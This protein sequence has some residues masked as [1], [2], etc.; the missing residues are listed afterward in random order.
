MPF[1]QGGPQFG[2]RKCIGGKWDG[3]G[4]YSD[5]ITFFGVRV[6][7]VQQEVQSQDLDGDDTTLA[8]QTTIKKATVTLAMAS[9][10]Q[11]GISL[12]TGNPVV[13][14]GSM[15]RLMVTSRKPPYIGI[16][17][18]AEAAEG[19][20]DTHLFIP[21][22]KMAQG[23][24]IRFELDTFSIPQFSLTAV[25]D[26]NFVDEDDYPLLYDIDEHANVTAVALP[27]VGL[28]A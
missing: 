21:K 15:T 12:I 16:A 27:P 4:S 20:G 13:D 8:T 1:D 6:L 7:G 3:D 17:G 22:A 19:N 5:Q 18:K 9:V 25:A 24:E 23:F 11:G 14:S 26:E 10:Q 2:V 28:G